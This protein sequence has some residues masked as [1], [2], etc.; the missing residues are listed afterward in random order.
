MFAELS[1]S[2][3]PPKDGVNSGTSDLD[4]HISEI[5]PKV[6]EGAAARAAAPV[7]AFCQKL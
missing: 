7:S 6:T 5:I 4:L 3:W 1:T 2:L